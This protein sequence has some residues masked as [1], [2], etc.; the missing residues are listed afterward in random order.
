M[1][2][3]ICLL[4]AIFA[5]VWISNSFAQERVQGAYYGLAPTVTTVEG[6][7]ITGEVS[8]TPTFVHINGEKA[9]FNEYRDLRDF[10]VYTGAAVKYD[11]DKY[12][13]D[14]RASDIGYRTQRYDLDG[15]WWGN[16][17]FHLGYQEIPHN[18]TFNAKSFY[19]GIGGSG[20]Q[21]S[22]PVNTNVNTWTTFDYSINRENYNGGFKIEAFKPFFFAV[23]ASKENKRGVF[24]IGTAGTSPGGISI[25]LP[26]PINYQTNTVSLE[27][28][29]AKNPL[30]LSLN[31]LYSTFDND[32]RNLNFINVATANT[33]STTDTFT[34]PPENDFRK[35]GAKMALKLPIWNTKFD[36][37]LAHAQGKSSANLL[38][39]YVSD[40][41]A[42]T[43]NIGVR[44][45]TGITL[46]DF[47]FNGK[48]DS[49]NYDFALTTHPFF[50][51]D[52]K[53]F[54]RYYN[55]QNKSDK[56]STLDTTV[57]ATPFFNTLFDYSRVKTGGEVGFRLPFNFVLT[58]SYT[59][60]QT[61]RQREDIPEDRDNI[62]ALDL[63]WSG[64]DFLLVRAGYERLQRRAD[65]Q[66]PEV[67]SLNTYL[68]RYDAATKNQDTYKLSVDIF[69]IE[70]LTVSA[71]FRKRAAD[72][73]DTL[74]GLRR[75]TTNEYNLDA[76]YVIRKRVRL[77]GYF[78]FSYA[79]LDQFQRSTSGA[80]FNPNSTPTAS[81]FNWTVTETDRNY[82]YGLGSDVYIIPS[83]F[84]L[85]LQHNY[86]NSDGYAD[87][88][89]LL[90][91]NLLAAQAPINTR[92]QDN[93]DI[94]NLDSYTLQYYLAK[95]TYD[96]GKGLS[97]AAGYAYE[98]YRLDDA[99]IN[100]YTFIPKSSTG[101]TLSYLTGAYS[102]PNYSANIFFMSAAYRF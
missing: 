48:L 63:R 51:L 78:D 55:T 46:S 97:V 82:A 96:I 61:K 99:Q 100:G 10:G 92:T 86:V 36:M 74:L 13:L 73:K 52:G 23:N 68:R 77:F 22:F 33:A 54:Y 19:T 56:I 71:A 37:N 53:V 42:A 9:K 91:G 44:G 35:Y 101:S 16:V 93:I 62:Y 7:N 57:Q 64:V 38:S 70:N 41:T 60:V 50:W 69:P 12:F 31:Y 76:D 83:K 66:E 11:S 90:P 84:A 8:A 29:Y 17:K 79:K 32:N 26:S 24:P 18:F 58:P 45:R 40:V 39:S 87:Y 89:Y 3:K 21:T 75:S 20:L 94:H 15:G 2:S 5:C 4:A 49:Q 59:Y 67:D 28:G 88:T 98:K 6:K 80:P 65:F 14:F 85:R 72:Y 102:N 43:S 1:K 95:L 81:S 47:V 30:V 34:L 25:E 27:G